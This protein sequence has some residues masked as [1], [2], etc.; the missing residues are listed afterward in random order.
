M[1]VQLAVFYATI[2][3]YTQFWRK[4]FDLEQ[5]NLLSK[6]CLGTNCDKLYVLTNIN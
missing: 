6:K 5:M 2:V 4:N 1:S 3:Q